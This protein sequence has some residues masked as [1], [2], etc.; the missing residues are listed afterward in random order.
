M[1]CIGNT[2]NTRKTCKANKDRL[3]EDRDNKETHSKWKLIPDD[4]QQI[5]LLLQSEFEAKARML[6]KETQFWW[7]KNNLYKYLQRRSVEEIGWLDIVLSNKIRN[8][9][10]NIAKEQIK[11]IEK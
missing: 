8:K 3:W 4:Y 11:E 6:P 1:I 2:I 9:F 10:V 7:D 5:E